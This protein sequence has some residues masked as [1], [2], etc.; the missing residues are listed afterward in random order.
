MLKKLV[1]V[2]LTVTMA[3]SMA[4][5]GSSASS[6][7]G[8]STASGG[9]ET[10]SFDGTLTV[11][12]SDSLGNF[13]KGS[14]VGENYVGNY[15]IYD[16]I[17]YHDPETKEVKSDVLEDWYYEDDLTFVMKLKDGV[18]FNN[19]DKATAEDLIFS[20]TNYAER[21]A[22][23]AS[24]FSTV[25]ADACYT[26][27]DQTAVIKF[28]EAWG[29][30]LYTV[31]PPL[32]DK[33]WCEEVGWDSEEW[34]NNPVGSGPY[35]VVD[36][37]TDSHA[38]FELRDDYWGDETM[39][40]SEIKEI[41][42]KYYAEISTLFVDLQTDAI[43]LALNIAESDYKRGLDDAISGV[44]VDRVSTNEVEFL[45]MDIKNEYLANEDFRK[46][47]AYGVN[48]NDVADAGFG[49][50]CDPATS[51]INSN[52]IYYKEEEG[53]SYDKDKALEYLEASGYSGEEITFNF[54]AMADADQ[55]NMVEA[56][57]YYMSE[58]GITV[59][60]EFYDF[61]TALQAWLEEGG[62]DFNFQES[63][64]GSPSGEPYISLNA[65]MPGYGAFPITTIDDEKFEELA[66]TLMTTMDED[67]RKEAAGELQD[68]AY[69]HA[70]TIPI[71]E[72]YYA[73]AYNNN[74][75]QSCNFDSAIS[76]NLRNITLVGQE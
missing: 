4:A 65:L 60:C 58:L 24:I 42:V 75:I 38:T 46:A 59:N 43:D 18:T 67:A 21:N 33:S 29:P 73:Y 49:T 7:S 20:F 6:A 17:F 31:D 48:W 53:Y 64:T 10:A 12:I 25:D 55:Q 26:E 19:G 35:K 13:L 28:T 5:C 16:C 32:Y 54:V 76:A 9:E 47:I 8:D 36:Y 41:E 37:A 57:Q 39:Y 45:C 15:L 51:I 30:G 69:E 40:N 66:M 2:L 14:S 68:Y 22:M 56:F 27:D 1:A 34:M 23:T 52:S 62:T 11:G 63:A 3:V 70:L 71:L 44:T 74:V 50:L 72:G 61:G